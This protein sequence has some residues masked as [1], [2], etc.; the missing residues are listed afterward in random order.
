MTERDAIRFVRRDFIKLSSS[1]AATAVLSNSLWSRAMA[2]PIQSGPGPYGALLPPDGNGI[3]LPPGFSARVI[4]RAGQRVASTGYTWHVF[5]DGGATFAMANG[6]YVY[7]SNSEFVPGGGVSAIRFNAAG[8]ALSAYRICTGTQLNCAGGKTP[9]G[10]WLTC[11]EFTGGHVW[12]CDPARANSQV[13]RRG[14][15]MIR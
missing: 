15:G 13:R 6:E 4:A 10:T 8:Q 12:E 14:L 7:V 5:P 9:W 11:E 3:M 2:A 1:L